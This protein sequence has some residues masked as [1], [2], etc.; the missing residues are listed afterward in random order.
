[1]EVSTLALA[2]DLRF[3]VMAGIMGL[4]ALLGSKNLDVGC[5]NNGEAR[6]ALI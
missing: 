5:E 4:E 1:M 2:L 3:P 6:L